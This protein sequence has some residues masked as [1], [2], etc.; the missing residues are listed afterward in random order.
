MIYKLHEGPVRCLH[1]F[2]DDSGFI[3]GGWDGNVFCWKLYTDKK[4]PK[5][6]NPQFHYKLKNFQFTCVAN[7]P[8]SK[9]VIYAASSDKTIKTIS[10]GNLQTTYETGVNISQI[11]LLNGGRAM[12]AGVA[13][14]DRP[15]SIQVINMKWQKISEIQA[16][17]LPLERIR[18]SHDNQYLYSAGQDG[19]FG[20]FS[21]SDKDPN[22]KDKEFSNQVQASEEIL[23]EKQERDKF[24]ADIENLKNKIEIEKQNK[25]ATVQ[26]ELDRKQKKIAE[27]T[28]EIDNKEIE[29]NH[30]YENLL[31]SKKEMER[32]NKDKIEQMMSAHD[33][34]MSQRKSDYADKM[35]ADQ[36]RF[37]ELQNQK[38]DDTKRFEERLNELS[39]HHEKIIKELIQ[40][41]KL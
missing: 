21:I 5:D 30:R 26:A 33:I 18:V 19:V 14:N 36:Q 2:D 3:S 4:D 41:Q 38:D 7:Q 39:L 10:G 34:M 29:N 35:D 40:D 13:E 1:W 15:G 6:E 24:Q 8:D 28:S 37:D 27:L 11:K 31:E 9:S 17:S 16:H 23:I 12:F 32:M 20:T 22:K 25:E